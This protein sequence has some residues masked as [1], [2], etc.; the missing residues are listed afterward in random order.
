MTDEL[1][2][3]ILERLDALSGLPAQVEALS[4]LPAQVEA[5]SALPA[6]VE[7]LSMQV[8]TLNMLPQQISEM[9]TEIEEL[10][11]RVGRSS[12]AMRDVQDDIHA[13]HSRLA[14]HASLIADIGQRSMMPTPSSTARKRFQ[15]ALMGVTSTMA[16][17]QIVPD[18]YQ[19]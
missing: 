18:R 16:G 15:V 2:A 17:F 11:A 4:A 8:K 9:R 7:A 13:T 6:Q 19:D 3:R 5:L 1:V 14:A 10:Q 12:R